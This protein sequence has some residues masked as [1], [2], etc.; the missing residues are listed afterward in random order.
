MSK[1]ARQKRLNEAINR[2]A[3]LFEYGAL[4]ADTD[5]AELFNKATDE[6]VQLRA[7]LAFLESQVSVEKITRDLERLHEAVQSSPKRST[8]DGTK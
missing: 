3:G 5:P 7:K 6:I 8:A 4:M 2:F 1:H